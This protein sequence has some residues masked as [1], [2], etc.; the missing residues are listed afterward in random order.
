VVEKLQIVLLC[1]EHF[2]LH[3]FYCQKTLQEHEAG[4]GHCANVLNHVYRNLKGHCF[5][6]FYAKPI[7]MNT[8]SESNT[9]L[10]IWIVMAAIFLSIALLWIATVKE[11][12]QLTTDDHEKVAVPYE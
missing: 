3:Y 12:N 1:Q 9:T 4:Y 8:R 2:L 6:L 10:A 5:F 7:V 11:G